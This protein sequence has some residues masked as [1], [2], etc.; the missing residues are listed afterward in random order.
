MGDVYLLKARVAGAYEH[1][2]QSI[3]SYACKIKSGKLLYNPDRVIKAYG[4]AAEQCLDFI[5]GYKLTE[6]DIAF[7]SQLDIVNREI[8][9]CS[10]RILDMSTDVS[11]AK[12]PLEF[13]HLS[14]AYL[15]ILERYIVI[16]DA[17][18]DCMKESASEE[19]S[20]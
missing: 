3:H 7:D 2:T 9:T 12:E 14:S 16:R 18:L 6:P 20:K 1:F 5:L 13:M 19:E 15:C 10:A 4:R 17:L 8:E 11:K